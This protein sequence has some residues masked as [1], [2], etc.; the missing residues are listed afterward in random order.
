MHNKVET[1]TAAQS[2]KTFFSD[3]QTKYETS[4]R[5]IEAELLYDERKMDLTSYVLKPSFL[6]Y[7]YNHR[8]DPKQNNYNFWYRRGQRPATATTFLY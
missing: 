1:N 7:S 3:I 6:F 5:F 4:V 2:K 8:N